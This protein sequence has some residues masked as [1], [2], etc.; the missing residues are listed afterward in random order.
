MLDLS[1]NNGDVDRN[2]RKIIKG[3]RQGIAIKND[4]ICRIALGENTAIVFIPVEEVAALG[5]K[6]E[7]LFP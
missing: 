7:D 5:A 6:A 2:V 4:N 1:V 3:A